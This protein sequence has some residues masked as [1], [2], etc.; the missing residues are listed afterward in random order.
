MIILLVQTG[1]LWQENVQIDLKTNKSCEY[2]M[3]FKNFPTVQAN[4][5]KYL[6]ASEP[7]KLQDFC[8]QLSQWLCHIMMY[9]I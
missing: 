7:I 6:T 1:W 3:N 2:M 5:M 8:N 4:R 9:D